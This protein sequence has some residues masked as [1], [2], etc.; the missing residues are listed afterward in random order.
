M[1]NEPKLGILIEPS[2]VSLS[3]SLSRVLAMLVASTH[4][5]FSF[6]ASAEGY[7]V[8]CVLCFLCQNCQTGWSSHFLPRSN[9]VDVIA[10]CLKLCKLNIRNPLLDGI[11]ILFSMLHSLPF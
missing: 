9:L 6:A 8:F 11:F 1:A 2:L 7:T 5:Y 10:L 4:C 3:L